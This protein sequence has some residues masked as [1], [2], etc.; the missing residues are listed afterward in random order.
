[1][2]EVPTYGCPSTNWYTRGTVLVAVAA[3]AAVAVVLVVVVAVAV[4]SADVISSIFLLLG[5]DIFS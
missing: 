5:V 4:L 2:S 3:V 1:V